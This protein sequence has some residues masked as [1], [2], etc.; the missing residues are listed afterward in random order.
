MARSLGR[1]HH[2]GAAGPGENVCEALAAGFIVAMMQSSVARRKSCIAGA[3][4]LEVERRCAAWD[5]DEVSELRRPKGRLVGVGRGVQDEKVGPARPG[6]VDQDW[7][8][9][10]LP[11]HDLRGVGL[12]AIPQLAAVPCG[13]RS[14]IAAACPAEAAAVARCTATVFFRAPPF[15]LMMAIVF[16]SA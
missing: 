15:R 6:D 3:K 11:A 4:E 1:A 14:M 16:M 12:T 5:E 10:R 2:F 9:G 7:Q 8:P 13:S